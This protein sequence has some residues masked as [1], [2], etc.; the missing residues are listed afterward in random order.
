MSFTKE[1]IKFLKKYYP[2]RSTTWCAKKLNKRPKQIT[3]QS[4]KLG[5]KRAFS[6]FKGQPKPPTR[7]AI[8]Q[9]VLSID[10][11]KKLQQLM[12]SGLSYKKALKEL[13]RTKNTEKL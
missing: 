4:G 12:S 11:R 3:Y 5:I 10:N 2:I 13:W 8:A 9:R 7:D 6:T 1:E